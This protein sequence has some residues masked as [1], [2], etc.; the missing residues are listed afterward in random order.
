[1]LGAA[2]PGIAPPE[3]SFGYRA[4]ADASLT[5]GD[6]LR[7]AL[8]TLRRFDSFASLAD[9]RASGAEICYERMPVAGGLGIQA[10]VDFTRAYA[11]GARQPGA[12]FAALPAIDGAQFAQ[13]PFT[14]GRVALAYRTSVSE[15]DFGSTLLG[16]NNGLAGHAIVLGDASLRIPLAGYADLRVGVQNLFG[17]SIADPFLA[18]LYP[19]HEFTLSVGRSSAP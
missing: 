19:A 5:N 6:H 3:T 16:A 4:S 2:A 17:Q 7:L 1:V 10:A 8:F 18:P 13:D 14:K 15:L 12:R 9:A 11:F